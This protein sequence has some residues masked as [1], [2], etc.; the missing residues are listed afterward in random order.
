MGDVD[1]FKNYN[2]RNGHEAGNRLLRDLA[3]V[4]RTSI[5]DEDLLC[6]Y[7]GEEFLFFLS[8]VKN[9]EE[10]TL[11]TERIRKSV[12][13]HVFEYEEFQPRHDLTMSF[14]VTM[15]PLERIGRR[16]RRDDQGRRSRNSPTRPT[17]PWPKPRARSC[18]PCR[19]I[20][21]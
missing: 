6:R 17:W 1:W 7:G 19:W 2:D 20:R 10:A 5:R 8:G 21:A 9:I 15:L 12:E 14:G 11:L 13:D 16:L 3:A 18:P 4:L